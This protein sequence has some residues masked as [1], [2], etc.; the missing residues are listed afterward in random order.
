MDVEQLIQPDKGHSRPA[1]TNTLCHTS[2]CRHNNLGNFGTPEEAA[3]A[4]LQHHQKEHPEELEHIIPGN[5]Y[6]TQAISTFPG[7]QYNRGMRE[8][9]PLAQGAAT[10]IVLA[11][12]GRPLRHMPALLHILAHVT[13][14]ASVKVDHNDKKQNKHCTL[15]GLPVCKL[16]STQIRSLLGTCLTLNTCKPFITVCLA[17]S[18]MS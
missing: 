7:N 14:P 3:Q 10:E 13:S 15:M 1:T 4:Y 2:P 12:Q 18:Q 8:S 17:F 6:V 16:H 5:Q 11:G 9:P